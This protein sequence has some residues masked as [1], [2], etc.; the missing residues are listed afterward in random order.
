M[1]YT[2]EREA[3]SYGFWFFILNKNLIINVLYNL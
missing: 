3:Q 1:I 2:Q